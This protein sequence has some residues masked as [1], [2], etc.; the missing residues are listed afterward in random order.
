MTER[1]AKK[2]EEDIKRFNVTNSKKAKN[3]SCRKKL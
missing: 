1:Q 2:V 3:K